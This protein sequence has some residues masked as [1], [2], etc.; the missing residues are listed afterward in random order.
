MWRFEQKTGNVYRRKAD[1]EP[2]VFVVSGYSGFSIGKNNPELQVS[3][4]IGPIPVGLYTFGSPHESEHLGHY[5]LDLI[6]D[7]STKTFGRGDFRLHGDN[8]EH[9]GMASH[10]C[11]IV[12]RLYRQQMWESGDH[13]LEVVSGILPAT[14]EAF[15]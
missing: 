8:V 6:P 2:L 12:P 9:P 13:T 7:K 11:I 15:V 5:V 10:G 3:H 14:T 4:G 1:G